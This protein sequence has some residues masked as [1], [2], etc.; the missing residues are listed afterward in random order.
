MSQPNIDLSI[1]IPAYMEAHGIAGVLADLSAF[2]KTRQYGNVEVIVVVADSPDGTARIAQSQA[3]LFSHFRVI[4][5]GPRMGKGFQVRCGIVEAR[6]R[7]RVFMDADLAT[8]LHH[9]DE[10]Y[11]AMEHGSKVVIAVR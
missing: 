11:D 2:L 4:K 6:G 10:V 5:S 3:K 9:L 7:Y 8:P 1:V